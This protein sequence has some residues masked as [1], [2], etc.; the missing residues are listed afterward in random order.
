MT[1]TNSRIHYEAAFQVRGAEGSKVF[2][3]I[4]ETIL[5]WIKQKEGNFFNLALE[6][7]RG[8]CTWQNVRNSHSHLSTMCFQEHDQNIGW[9]LFFHETDRS[10]P[11]KRFWYTDVGLKLISA[12]TVTVCVKVSHGLN[13][14]FVG[15]EP[16]PP[17]PSAPRFVRDI[18][19]KTGLTI[20]SSR[21]QLSWMAREIRSGEVH[22]LEDAI[23]NTAR[24]CPVIFV[25]G[26]FH[27]E[28]FPISPDN[29][30]RDLVGKAQVFWSGDDCELGEELKFML[31]RD[32]IGRYRSIRV[33]L[34]KVDR[35]VE[36]DNFRH[37]FFTGYEIQE[38]GAS[39]IIDAIVSAIAR[40]HSNREADSFLTHADL[41][42]HVRALK[43]NRLTSE[44]EPTQEWIQTLQEEIKRLE[45]KCDLND[46]L[47]K[48]G[49]RQISSLQ[50]DCFKSEAQT[51]RLL[52]MRLERTRGESDTGLLA[53]RKLSNNADKA[54]PLDCLH[55]LMFLYPDRVRILPTAFNSA[56][57]SDGFRHTEGLWDLLETLGNNYYNTMCGD[58][59]G[60]D[61]KARSVF[62]SQ[63]SAQESEA[64]TRSPRL[65]KTREFIDG[66]TKRTMFRHLK[67][68]VKDSIAETIRVHFDWDSDTK[69]I[70]IG[71]CGPHLPL[72]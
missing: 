7:F 59:G 28:Y 54:K 49:D 17:L 20:L 61:E 44:N 6:A 68:G 52:A 31:P 57:D 37:R 25:N 64:V 71:Y 30:Q 58:G 53:Y 12:S 2:G 34:P 47:I 36:G 24:S 13:R 15:M 67:I 70:I 60:G 8:D 63:Y 26:A 10:L 45:E 33:Y 23:F 3:Q 42:A 5:A 22:L 46:E 32:Y 50:A 9:S 38:L 55:G 16:N 19:Q 11:G 27:P 56:M 41:Y 69:T 4:Q 40:G 62:G 48:E 39:R 51:Q 14:E 21:L 65:C 18:F 1:P 29:L 43:L 35:N 72:V 66:D